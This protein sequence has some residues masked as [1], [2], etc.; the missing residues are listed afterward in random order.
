MD[1]FLIR[2]APCNIT[3]LCTVQSLFNKVN[4]MMYNYS[5]LLI[6]IITPIKQTQQKF[7]QFLRSSSSILT[8]SCYMFRIEKCC[9][10]YFDFLIFFLNRFVSSSLNLVEIEAMKSNLKRNKN[11]TYDQKGNFFGTPRGEITGKF[12]IESVKWYDSL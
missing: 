12:K 6:T 8:I 2:L 1:V 10:T 3:I 9:S 4:K 5:I 11:M 7:S